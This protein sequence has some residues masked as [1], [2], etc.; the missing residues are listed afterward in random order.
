[1]TAFA[2][3]QKGIVRDQWMGTAAGDLLQ[4]RAYLHLAQAVDLAVLN[5]F[6]LALGQA[7]AIAFDVDAVA[8]GIGEIKGLLAVADLGMATRDDAL[9]VGQ[10]PVAVGGA[11]DDAAGL[12][13]LAGK[14]WLLR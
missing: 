14:R 10:H 11:A 9:A 5:A 12:T 1:M 6:G 4:P 8:T 13:E 3:R 7:A 2:Q